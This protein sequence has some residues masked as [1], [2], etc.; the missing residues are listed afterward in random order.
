MEQWLQKEVQ[1][2]VSEGV[3]KHVDAVAEDVV[4]A[5]GSGM[6]GYP[7]MPGPPAT[8]FDTTFP[9]TRNI[10]L[11][12]IGHTILFST[13]SGVVQSIFC[14]MISD[15]AFTS[16][17]QQADI[18]VS[19]NGIPLT[20]MGLPGVTA[21]SNLQEAMSKMRSVSSQKTI[22]FFRASRPIS[23]DGATSSL[24]LDDATVL[25][26]HGGHIGETD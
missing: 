7:D 4:V 23:E 11:T 13:P 9:D 5:N 24:N 18:A 8:F 22:R 2:R 12:F 1:R 14:C 19:I 3:K 16:D 25:L 20:S 21:E 6:A 10:G 26:Q 15:S 17:V